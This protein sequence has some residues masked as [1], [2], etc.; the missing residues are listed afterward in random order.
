MRVLGVDPGS[1]VTGWG[2][3]AGS[4]ERPSLVESGV[5]R[6][7]RSSVPLAERLHRL[8]R[9]LDELVGR[10]S[11]VAAAVEAPFI[12]VNARAALQLAHARGVVLAMLAAVDVPVI[13]YAPA[14]VKVAVTG[15][16]RADKDQVRA[17]VTRLLGLETVPGPAD[18]TDALAV[19]LCHLSSERYTRAVSGK[20]VKS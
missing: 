7:G 2:M 16:G 9:G 14:A 8:A 4:A 1:I 15:N 17:M 11:P 19:A 3:L 13:E 18:R 12:G 6:L 20:G 10:L 5:I